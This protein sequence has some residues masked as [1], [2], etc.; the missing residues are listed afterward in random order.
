MTSKKKEPVKVK[1]YE[2]NTVEEAIKFALLELGL[3]KERIKIKILTEGNRGLFGME[4]AKKAKIRV[5]IQS[6]KTPES[7]E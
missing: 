5:T 7:S 2:A 6:K 4:G 1:E 3:P